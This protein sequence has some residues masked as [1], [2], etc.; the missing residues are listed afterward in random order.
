VTDSRIDGDAAADFKVVGPDPFGRTLGQAETMEIQIVMAPQ[1]SQPAF[2][3]RR[4]DPARRR[5][6]PTD[7]TGVASHDAAVTVARPTTVQRR[8]QRPAITIWDLHGLRLPERAAKW[9]G[10][11]TLKWPRHHR[12]SGYPSPPGRGPRSW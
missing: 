4:C 2:A 6:T 5:E 11:T 12:R 3:T 9:I 8:R 10:S 1:R 7:L